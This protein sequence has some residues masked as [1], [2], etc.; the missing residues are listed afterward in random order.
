LACLISAK[1]GFAKWRIRSSIS[2][3]DYV[4]GH[5]STPSSPNI[6]LVRWSPPQPGTVKLNFN[7]SYINSAARGGFILRDR[8][9]KLL[10]A[11]AANYGLTS[12]LV[13]EAKALKDGVFLAVQAGYSRI[14]IE[15]DNMIVIQALKG[16][17]QMPWQIAYIIKDVKASFQHVVQ[18]SI[19]HI[20]R[21]A[22]MAAE[23]FSKFGHS[24]T[25]F[26]ITGLCFSPNLVKLLLILYCNTLE[27]RDN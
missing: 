23:W 22:N 26:F 21:K 10:K 14:S 4:K 19:N 25:D 9:G 17:G 2:L 7:G 8:T 11:G 3:D 16:E 13:A 27:R 15:G 20:Y 5:S 6:R 1:K 24:I 18:V 12:S